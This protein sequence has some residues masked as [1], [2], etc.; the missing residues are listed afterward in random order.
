MKKSAEK[1]VIGDSKINELQSE[2]GSRSW[3]EFMQ[4]DELVSKYW[5]RLYDEFIDFQFAFF[6]DEELSGVGNTI[7]LN[8]NRQQNDLP[9]TG[10]DWAVQKANDDFIK[11]LKP[12]IL[13]AVQ[14]LI[15]PDFR[16]G[17]LS[18]KMLDIMKD[19]AAE[20]GMEYIALPVRPTLK[21]KYPLIPTDKYIQWK[22]K[23]GFPFDPWI[24]VHIKAG[25][26]IVKSCN[27][28]MDIRGTI[29]E[30]EKWTNM[31]FQSSGD[32]VIDGALCPVKIDL[33]KDIGIYLEPNV[34]I[35]HEITGK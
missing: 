27:R 7:P 14:I 15:N 22:D 3:P 18:Y 1:I 32:Y 34:W 17:G 26:K 16:G 24:R 4:H 19:I 2:L 10:L 9:D 23:E 11:G 33:T 8:W 6:K 21:N 13:I 5:L 20:K 31:S 12:N 28:S 30:W 25:G 29:T 35:V